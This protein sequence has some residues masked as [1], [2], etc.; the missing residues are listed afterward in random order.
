MYSLS[1][2][3]L[4]NS[5]DSSPPGFSVHGDSPDNTGVGC[6]AHL[7]GIFPTQ[8]SCITHGFFTIWATREAQE[9][10]SGKP[11]PSAGDLPDPGIEPG[12]PALQ[13]D[14]LPAELWPFIIRIFP[15]RIRENRIGLGLSHQ[16]LWTVF[17]WSPAATHGYSPHSWIAEAWALSKPF[18]FLSEGNM[19]GIWGDMS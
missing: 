15:W 14:S 6:H 7:W 3:Q 2:V 16:W 4:C 5:M 11:I 12:S 13:A 17:P 9:Y 19:Q 8:V 18:E 10:W 1:C